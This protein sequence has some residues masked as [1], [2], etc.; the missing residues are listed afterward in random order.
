MLLLSSSANYNSHFPDTIIDI[1]MSDSLESDSTESIDHEDGVNE[2]LTETEEGSGD[3]DEYEEWSDID[4]D[5]DE[6]QGLNS[7]D[8]S[9]SDSDHNHS[10]DSD[11]DVQIVQQPVEAKLCPIH[12]YGEMTKTCESCAAAFSLIKDQRSEHHR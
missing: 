12:N 2:H 1:T 5:D 11:A 7:D 3:T 8:R 4:N 6:S 9:E 10:S